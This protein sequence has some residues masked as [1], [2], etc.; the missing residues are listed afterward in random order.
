MMPAFTTNTVPDSAAKTL[1]LAPPSI[2][3]HEERLAA[4]AAGHERA[5]LEIQMLDRL[6]AGIVTLPQSRY[7]L[8]R[9]LSDAEG[10]DVETTRL[11]DR[12]LIHMLADALTPRGRLESQDSRLVNDIMSP[13][14]REAIL[15]GL[16]LEDGQLVKPESSESEAV[17]LRVLARPKATTSPRSKTQTLEG[18]LK[19]DETTSANHQ[20]PPPYPLGVGFVTPDHGI[21]N[22][23]LSSED[24]EELI[25]EDTLLTE[26]ELKR[27]VNIPAACA[28]RAG[29]RRRACK[30]CTCG[31]A[32]KIEAENAARRVAADAD[33]RTLQFR[34]DELAEID[35][36]VQGKVGSCGN[37]SLGDAFRCE[38]CPYIGMPAF[39]PGDEVR[40][41]NDDIQL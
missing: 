13:V 20:E 40:L 36:T 37:C 10:S 8:I 6:A 24:D 28:P 25:D 3:R 9:I 39:N 14:Y 22:G 17:P 15:A 35:F 27:P 23:S 33:L 32:A 29:K 26:E 31:L 21:D 2:A 7:N 38:G 18:V 1:L 16:L 34:S 4:A 41:L 5:S 11:L 12:P 19:F 30:D